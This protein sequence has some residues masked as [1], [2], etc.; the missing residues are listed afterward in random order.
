MNKSA[1][2]GLSAK[3]NRK[4]DFTSSWNQRL[5]GLKTCNATVRNTA[6]VTY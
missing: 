4:I 1:A 5:E 2:E 3:S 6:R